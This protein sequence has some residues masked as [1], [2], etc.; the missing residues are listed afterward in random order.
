MGF[1]AGSIIAVAFF[2]LMPEALELGSKYYSLHA[3][4]SCIAI[5]FIIYLLFDRID[6][7]RSADDEHC[8]NTH[9][10][11]IGAGNLFIHSFLDGAAIGI[12]F[13]AASSVGLAIAIGVV[14]HHISDGMNTVNLLLR[15]KQ[16]KI[17]QW[18]L[19]N[20][21]APAFG[22]LSTRFFVVPQEI[23]SPLLAIFC[24]FFLY[25][26]ASD[27]LPE[28]HHNHPTRW[29]TISTLVGMVFLYS[30]IKLAQLN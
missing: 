24:G 6:V 11:K 10:G 16:S 2:D 5:G 28:S 19:L 26:G 30:A 12:G 22:M 7:L 20:A 1:G 27:L 3:I 9:H 13:Q 17:N 25:M 15:N 8:E 14:I 21:L 29:T 23:L 4:T 18:L